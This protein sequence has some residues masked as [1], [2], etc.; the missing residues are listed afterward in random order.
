L[1]GAG[2]LRQ[3]NP[4][5]STPGELGLCDTDIKLVRF[6]PQGSVDS[7]FNSPV[8]DFGPDLS[9]GAS[10]TSLAVQTDGRV[11]VGGG[12]A[13]VGTSDFGLARFNTDGSFDATF[14]NA[15]KVI[16]AFPNASAG[17]KV[18][19]LQPNGLIVATVTP[20]AEVRRTCWPRG[21]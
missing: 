9:S 5:S 14:G 10:A 12:A 16:T 20:S 1:L 18:V 17:V 13:E 15:G 11:V 4:P 8:F 2:E 3:P 6:L 7:T 21:T 19:I